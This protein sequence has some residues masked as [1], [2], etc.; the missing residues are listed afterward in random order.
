M[1]IFYNIVK[2]QILEIDLYT[3]WL[4]EIVSRKGTRMNKIFK[5]IWS[6]SKQCYV[7]VSEIAKNKTGKKKIVVVSILAILAMAGTGNSVE[8]A[9]T[10]GT[11]S[12]PFGVGMGGPS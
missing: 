9:F 11:T 5:V 2:I 1:R 12:D 7:V 3:I 6:K 8:G 10:K 4:W